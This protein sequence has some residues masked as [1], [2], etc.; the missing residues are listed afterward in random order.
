MLHRAIIKR[1][2]PI[3]KVILEIERNALWVL[4]RMH[5]RNI[6]GESVKIVGLKSVAD[7]GGNRL[8]KGV[9]Q[10]PFV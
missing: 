1:L 8:K 5:D 6:I 10:L 3:P 2:R 9:P 7:G 4:N